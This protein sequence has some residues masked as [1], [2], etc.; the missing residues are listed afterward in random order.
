MTTHMRTSGQHN[1]AQ[2]NQ[3]YECACSTQVSEQAA[4][5]ELSRACTLTHRAGL[6]MNGEGAS[7]SKHMII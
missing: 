6:V 1:Q 7:M 4:I 5:W 2:H 3:Q